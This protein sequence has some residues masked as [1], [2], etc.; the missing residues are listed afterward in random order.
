MPERTSYKPGTPSWVD[1]SSPDTDA[2]ASFYGDLFGWDCSEPAPVEQTGGYRMFTK[3]GKAVAGLGP[4]QQEG[5]PPLW[6]TYVTVEDAEATAAKVKEAGGQAFMEP[7]DV[8]KFGRMAV[9]ADSTGAAFAVWQPGEHI[10]SEVVNE[11]GTLCWNELDTRDVEGAKKFYSDVFGWDYEPMPMGDSE[12]ITAKLGD[13][14]VAGIMAINDQFPPDVP[15][16][17]LTYIAVDDTDATTA[18]VNELGG[19]TVVEPM[20]SPAGRFACLADPHG[21]VFGV[22]AMNGSAA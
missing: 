5:M 8:L 20:D 2:A 19:K 21:A 4:V 7:M 10:G 18:R 1:V 15:N 11:S 6:T 3:G 22:V 12:Y 14:G 13:D 16:N 9:F 17:W